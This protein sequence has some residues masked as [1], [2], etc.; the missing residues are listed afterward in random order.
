VAL[1]RPL[2]YDV[3]TGRRVGEAGIGTG[4]LVC[5]EQRLD[6]VR[7]VLDGA[8]VVAGQV[9]LDAAR[10]ATME[11]RRGVQIL[12]RRK[13]SPRLLRRSLRA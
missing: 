11:I 10:H 5:V 12:A 1:V 6:A 4:C 2:W 3:S 7:A 9:V 8:E 13:H